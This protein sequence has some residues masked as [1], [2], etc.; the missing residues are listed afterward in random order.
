MV[1][2]NPLFRTQALSQVRSSL[3]DGSTGDVLAKN[4]SITSMRTEMRLRSQQWKEYHWVLGYTKEP[5]HPFIASDQVV[6]M[7]GN[8]L[9][10]VGRTAAK[11]LLAVVSAVLG[12]VLDRFVA[13]A[14]RRADRSASAERCERTAYS[15]LDQKSVTAWLGLRNEA[16][17]GEYGAYD[18]KQ[19]DVL[20]SEVEQFVAR[21]R[22]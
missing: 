13:A 16:A 7:R 10:S 14:R 6:G 19:V 1:T 2:R 21:T 5:E 22:A 4:F 8:A 15:A 18:G 20:I 9:T 3:A 17:H 12:Y 11:R